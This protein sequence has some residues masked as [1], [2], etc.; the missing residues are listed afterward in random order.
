MRNIV[1]LGLISFFM[2]V[3]S[4]MVY[5]IIPLYLTAAF[6]ATPA[7]VGI[8][9]GIAES[10]ASLLKVF[11]GYITDKYKKKK[12][13]AFAGYATGLLYKLALLFAGSWAGI[14]TAR[15]I[16]RLGKGIRT[17]PRDVMVSESAEDD[18]MGKAFGVHKALDMAG[19]ALGIILSYML[20]RG[21]A[22]GFTSGIGVGGTGSGMVDTYRLIFMISIAPTIL[23]LV[24]F[25]FVKEKKEPR[26][27]KEREKFWTGFS[28]LD[29][30]LK[31][32]LLI[33]FLFTLGNSSNTFLLLRAKSAGF[34][35]TN[36][37]LLYFLYNLT[38]SVLAVPFGKL[39]DRIGRK[40]VLTCG[41]LLFSAV[42]AG[43]AF[44]SSVP[45]FVVIFAVYGIFT[46]M[47]AGVERALIADI[48]PA[49]LKGT[50]LGLHSTVSGIALLPASVI[51][52]FL[53][54]SFG[55][56]VPFLFGAFMSMAAA[57]LLIVLFRQPG[58]GEC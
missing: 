32:Y 55:T 51:C 17:A 15:V 37:I 5:P 40:S 47:T 36:V 44:A 50:M 2:D 53:W 23:A 3:S 35:D 56:A 57:V 58:K 26:Q 8:I 7:L 14:L 48:A 43:F 24:M 27:I 10:T 13:I 22:G 19:S 52:G 31:L 9:E 34:D 21:L 29:G 4:E 20:L 39:S 33:V 25:A 46:A 28:S 18:T 11:S 30:R 45:A 16:D 38:A 49:R 12:P 6:G 41:Y 54:N 1:F 42:Y